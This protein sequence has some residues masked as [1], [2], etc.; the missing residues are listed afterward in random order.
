[1]PEPQFSISTISSTG[2]Q[3]LINTN[4]QMAGFLVGMKLTL[5]G[6]TAFPQFNGIVF[7]LV[8]TNNPSG[9][10]YQ[11]TM[12]GIMYSVTIY[13]NLHNW[14]VVSGPETGFVEVAPEVIGGRAMATLQ[15]NIDP[16]WFGIDNTQRRIIVQG[17]AQLMPDEPG[18]QTF[19]Y[20]QGGIRGVWG[21]LEPI[22]ATTLMPLWVQIESLSSGISYVWTPGAAVTNIE[23]VDGVLTATADNNFAENDEV[24]FRYLTGNADVFNGYG[25]GVTPL[26]PLKVTQSD[27]ST[28]QGNVGVEEMESTE[29][30]G[31]AIPVRYGPL[32]PP[33]LPPTLPSAPAMGFVKIL[34]NGT[35][36]SSIDN[37]TDVI[38]YR[39]EFMRSYF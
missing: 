37:P 10:R 8:A 5:T 31:L 21:Y 7:E 18:G 4:D 9:A 16:L 38:T 13:D 11:A 33:P 32:V 14:P 27:G 39:A 15:F 6:L 3:L 24:T 36:V 35:E 20:S 1:M 12:S 34:D 22:K 25:L 29:T 19:T 26:A 2:N 23:I 28:F 30:T 17:N